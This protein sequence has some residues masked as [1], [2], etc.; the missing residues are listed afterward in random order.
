[1]EERKKKIGIVTIHMINNYGA[2]LQAYALNSYLN[3]VGY[4]AETIDFRTYR[5]A[6]SYKTYAP[7][8]GPM[9][10]VRNLQTLTLMKKIRKR[11]ERMKGFIQENV[12]LSQGVYYSNAELAEA[13]L[14]YDYYICGSDQIWNTYCDNYDDAFILAFARD[15][16]IRLSYAASMG[17]SSVNPA[18]LQRFKE[19]LSGFSALSVR[20]QNA[21]EVISSISG[22][23]V[24]QVMDPVFLLSPDQWRQVMKRDLCPQRPYILFYS[25]HGGWPGM[26]KYVKQLSRLYHMPVVV[27]NKNLREALYPN[28]KCFDAGPAEFVGLLDGAKYIFTNS[29]HGCAFSIM[30]KKKFQVFV[31]GTASQ[32]TASRIYSLMNTLGLADRITSRDGNPA[33]MDNVIDWDNA[34]SKLQPMID[35]SKNYLDEALRT[36]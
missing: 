7:I 6:E 15:K 21:V 18:L 3:S 11:H 2:I 14:D 30:F 10:L 29:F 17:M 36:K 9:D 27:V 19:E 31:A 32:G 20:E 5:V 16:G 12:K 22:K 25:V 34:H 4:D 24:V 23:E 13:H 33:A 35:S 26:R 28:I 8:H 1:M